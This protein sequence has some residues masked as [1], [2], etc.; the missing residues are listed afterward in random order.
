M[1]TVNSST[2]LFVQRQMAA[3]ENGLVRSVQRL[4]SGLRINSARDDAAGLAISQRL[5][6]QVRGFDVALRNANDGIS[7]LQVAEFA[8]GSI[9]DNLQ[10]VRQLT[11]QAQNPALGGSEKKALQEEIGQ[12]FAEIN[13]I[14]TETTFNGEKVFSQSTTSI[15]GDPNKRTVMEALKGYWLKD[16]EDRVSQFYGLL[17]DGAT[18]QINLDFTDGVGGVAASVSGSLNGA[19]KVVNQFLNIDM[20]D[21]TPPT[22]PNGGTAPFYNDRVITHEIVHAVMGRTMNMGAMPSWFLEGTA[23]FIHGAD[24]RVAAD[25]ANNGGGASG[26]AAIMAEFGSV[27]SSEGYSAS[28]AATRYLHDKIKEAG[29][30]GIRDIMTYLNANQTHDLDQ[31]IAGASSG[32]FASL[33]A[34][35]ADFT[36]NGDAYIAGMN[37]TNTD[38]GAIGGLDADGGTVYTAK[39]IIPNQGGP[40][41]DDPM[42]GFQEI[43]PEIG[44]TPA[45]RSLKLQVGANAGDVMDVSMSAANTAALGLDGINV[46]NDNPFLTV[47]IDQALEFVNLKRA[48][49]GAT[50]NRLESTLRTVSIA[51]EQAQAARSRIQDADY[52]Q[53][54][55]RLTSQ[56]ILQEAGTSIA[57]Q[58]NAQPNMVLSLLR[59]TL[60]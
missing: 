48:E 4:S 37:L 21:F 11:V 47:R 10:R 1:L 27:A 59:N 57:V 19:G 8:Y 42:R 26:R 13:R 28:Y 44:G 45:S 22:L 60:N 35:E 50:M 51:G 56:R 52:A 2:S 32:A 16:A 23:E 15:G 38:T 33:A 46:V 53:E 17:G 43:W 36:A 34:F 20:A 49:L 5:T 31:A 6:S 29:G 18:L 14:A 24:E 40:Y 25:I 58:A 9:S 54:T 7:V 3:T 41:S 30:T 12:L 55:A 39:S